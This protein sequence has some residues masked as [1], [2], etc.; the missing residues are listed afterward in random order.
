MGGGAQGNVQRDLRAI[1]ILVSNRRGWLLKLFLCPSCF[2]LQA[3]ADVGG[4]EAQSR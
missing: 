1:I 2:V 3:R 4:T